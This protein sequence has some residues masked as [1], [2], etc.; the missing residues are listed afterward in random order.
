MGRAV[1]RDHG[2]YEPV[3]ATNDASTAL[4]D[5]LNER[6]ELIIELENLL[7]RLDEKHLFLA[8][9]HVDSAI[10]ALKAKKS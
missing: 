1:H 2:R 9:I 5:D 10:C 8:A 6:G 7:K 4:V 3:K